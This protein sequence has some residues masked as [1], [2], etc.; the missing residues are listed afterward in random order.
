V[1]AEVF[2]LALL[3]VL[4]PWEWEG[5]SAEPSEEEASWDVMGAVLALHMPAEAPLYF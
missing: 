4:N 1:Q 3:L 5:A 2:V